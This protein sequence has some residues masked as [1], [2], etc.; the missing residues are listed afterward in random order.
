M[1]GAVE[2]GVIGVAEND[3]D[4]SG[5]PDDD[6][7][8]TANVVDDECGGVADDDNVVKLELTASIQI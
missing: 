8:G 6:G 3:D 4:V 1:D 5:V 7:V 2:G